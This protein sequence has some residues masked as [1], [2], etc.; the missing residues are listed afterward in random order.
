MMTEMPVM[1]VIE[2]MSE[3]KRAY[4]RAFWAYLTN[5]ETLERPPEALESWQYYVA[6]DIRAE[7]AQFDT[8]TG[9]RIT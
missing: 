4:A 7:L 6:E 3:P 8:K 9:E 1:T 2:S 5:P